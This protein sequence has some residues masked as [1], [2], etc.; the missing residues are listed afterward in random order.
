MFLALICPS[1]ASSWLSSLR[2]YYD[3]WTNIHEIYF[4]SVAESVN[5]KNNHNDSSINNMDNTT[6]VLCL[7]QSFKN[8]FPNNEFKLSSATQVKNIIQ[9]KEFP[10]IWWN[11]Y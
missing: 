5:A 4:L 11:I 8:P 7:L 2:L 1:P 9:I 6:P 10:L 3:A